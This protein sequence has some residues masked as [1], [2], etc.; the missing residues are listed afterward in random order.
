MPYV[1]NEALPE[2]SHPSGVPASGLGPSTATRDPWPAELG[3]GTANEPLRVCRRPSSSVEGRDGLRLVCL[4]DTHNQLARVSIPDGD[5]FI[6]CGDAVNFW[7]SR[8]DLRRFN[9]LVGNLPHP[10]KLFVSGNHCVCLDENRPDLSQE[11]LSNMLYVQDQLVEIEGV[12]FYG[13]PWRPRRGCFYPSEAFGFDHRRIGEEK[14]SR[15]PSGVDVLLTHSPPFGV[16]DYSARHG[17]RLGCLQLLREELRRV[18]PRL[19]LFGHVHDSAGIA[20]FRSEANQ[21][22]LPAVAEPQREDEEQN[23]AFRIVF[24]NVAIQRARG[25]LGQPVVIDFFV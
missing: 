23:E 25:A 15:I 12:R 3:E 13:S 2:L 16:L 20:L 10:H 18:R 4:S 24:A 14:W 8:R 5:V 19:H 17:A 11:M 6:H 1:T 21:H 9:R 7:S 22:L